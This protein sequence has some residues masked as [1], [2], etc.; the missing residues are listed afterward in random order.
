MY[1]STNPLKTYA[2]TPSYMAPEITILEK[3]FGNRGGTYNQKADCWSLGVIL[4]SMLSGCSAFPEGSDQIQ[5]ILGGRYRPMN[6]FRW[7]GVSKQAKDLISSLLEVE[8][9]KRLSSD[10]ILEHP[11]IAGDELVVNIARNIMTS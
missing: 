9:E 2:G 7:L 10:Q 8:V 4:Y 6:D 11:W 1:S 3:E 5:R